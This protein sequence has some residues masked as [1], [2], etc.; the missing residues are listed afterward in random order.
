MCKQR[1]EEDQVRMG[2]IQGHVG[3]DATEG[4]RSAASL[5]GNSVVLRAKKTEE[6][7]GGHGERLIAP[8]Y[9]CGLD[10]PFRREIAKP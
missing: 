6:H 7:G 1:E 8:K 9:K 2:S 4:H 10:W 3:L 5:Q